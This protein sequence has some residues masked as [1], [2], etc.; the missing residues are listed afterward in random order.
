MGTGYSVKITDLP[1]GLNSEVLAQAIVHLLADMNHSMS[2]YLPDSELSRF[3]R[4]PSVDWI[5]ISSSLAEVLR[6]AQ[7][8]GRLSGGAFEVTVGSLV[9]LWGFGPSGYREAVPP[10]HQIEAAR[11]RAG[12]EQWQ[13]RQ[14]PPALRK[15][16][17][18]VYIDLS[19]IAK[20]Y[21]VD[22]VAEFLE[23]QGVDNY[24]VDIGGEGRSKGYSPREMPWRVAIEEPLLGERRV[25]RIV[26]LGTKAVA[27]SGDYRNYFEWQGKHYSHTIDPR[28]GWPVTHRLSSVTVLST[29][30]M[31][32][33]ALA[34][35]LM[36]LGP[37]EGLKWAAQKR[38]PALMIIKMS[39]GF[40][41]KVTPEFAASVLSPK[42][43]F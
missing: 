24:F 37:E 32:A 2:T 7:G 39:T 15:V 33:D 29:T 11:D 3:N 16:R 21:A 38:I 35:A 42:D 10:V 28:T 17:A 25:Q 30:A 31:R 34:T 27:T 18:D 14:S 1:P 5:P 20:G 43:A 9:N 26:E 41:E 4:N 22:R 40:V 13:L 19:G 8:I 6:E 12:A 23:N 36:V